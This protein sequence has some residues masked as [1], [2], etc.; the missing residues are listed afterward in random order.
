MSDAA[1]LDDKFRG[2]AG[3]RPPPDAPRVESALERLRL[4]R[5]VSFEWKQEVQ[6]GSRQR[7]LGVI[8]QEVEAVFPDA[9]ATGEDGFK[10]VDY[11]GLVA[12]LIEAVK[13]LSER[14]EALERAA[15][16]QPEKAP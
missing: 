4:V 5:G 15:D 14:L 11:A 10:L 3:D 12:V 16:V 2:E 6:P 1:D 13:E 9:V 7:E 8:A